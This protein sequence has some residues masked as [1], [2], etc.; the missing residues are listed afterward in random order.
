MNK[1]TISIGESTYILK[2]DE[3]DDEVDIDS[4]LRIDYSNLI[5][6]MLTFPTVVAKIGNMLAEAES[7]VNEKKLNL[8]VQEAK[9]KEEYRIK[10]SKE[11][12]GKNPTVDAL[13]SA[14]CN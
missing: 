7:V 13:S 5:G 12:G 3:F 9:L 6:E 14:L 8:D 10:L 2:F 1:K 11:N 4:L